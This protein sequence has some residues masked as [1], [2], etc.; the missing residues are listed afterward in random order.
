[1]LPESNGKSERR[2]TLLLQADVAAVA[3]PFPPKERRSFLAV[4]LT[5]TSAQNWLKLAA[6]MTCS[7]FLIR[8]LY[9]LEANKW[10]PLKLK[11]SKKAKIDDSV[12]FDS[13]DEDFMAEYMKM[14]TVSNE[15]ITEYSSKSLKS[16][17]ELTEKNE[18]PCPR[19][20]AMMAIYK[21]NLY[22]LGG[23][24]ELGD[25]E[26][27]L[28]DLSFVNY[29]KM[30]KFVIIKEL[31]LNG[32]EWMEEQDEDEDE[33]EDS[34]SDESETRDSSDSSESSEEEEIDASEAAEMPLLLPEESL[35]DY[36]NRTSK[37]FH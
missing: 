8:Y 18:F 14:D 6:T 4:F 20:N 5:N 1:M 17:E 34:E 11:Q 32:I 35:K 24:H 9:L 15:N 27:T 10:F 16:K 22:I 13:N 3:F 37:K 7:S 29:D 23:I 31:D 30:D 12:E 21:N 33:D 25:R 19:Y 26:Y 2:R 28:N 36:F